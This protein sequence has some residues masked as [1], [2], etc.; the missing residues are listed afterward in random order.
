MCWQY[1]ELI[2]ISLAALGSIQKQA[3]AGLCRDQTGSSWLPTSWLLIGGV[4]LELGGCEEC[5]WL[6]E[7]R[8]V[9]LGW[10]VVG[11]STQL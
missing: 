9:V 2:E 10:R 8:T 3:G 11:V 1:P 6:L 7:L 4:W 5:G